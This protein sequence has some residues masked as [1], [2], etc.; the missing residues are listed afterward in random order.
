MPE[1]SGRR[2]SRVAAV[3]GWA[4]LY[5][6][7]PSLPAAEV[8]LIT[9][10]TI[11]LAGGT[12]VPCW[13]PGRKDRSLDVLIHFHGAAP[14]VIKAFAAARIDAVFIVVNFRGLS[15]AY[16]KPFRESPNLFQE[17]LDATMRQ[18]RRSGKAGDKTQWDRV[19][20]SSFSAG[21]GAVREILKVPRQFDRIDGLLAADSIY[22]GLL[23][24]TPDRR[25]DE[26][27]MR[28]FV[29][30]SQL[31]VEG[32]KTFIITHS[33]LE[34]PYA[35]TKETADYLLKRLDAERETPAQTDAAPMRLVSRASKGDFTVLGYEGR[36]GA[37]HL[38]H[39][40]HIAQWWRQLPLLPAPA[41][42][43]Q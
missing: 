16:A 26:Q 11:T 42:G 31:A 5:C 23:A 35:S 41:A 9:G 24:G 29:R 32:K 18:L 2:W 15:S 7:A 6:C 28:P 43:R 37:A 12:F 14:V 20:L 21:Y 3:V 30:F 33:Y 36:T 34:T 39:L 38:Q 40:R 13:Y 1:R 17:V 4:A 27:Q 10:G 25:V 8:K 19:C 22:A